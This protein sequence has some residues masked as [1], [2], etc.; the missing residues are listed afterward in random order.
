[1]PDSMTRILSAVLTAIRV[2]TVVRPAAA[3]LLGA[4]LAG[5]AGDDS[6][7]RP[8]HIAAR[9]EGETVK[10][11]VSE[12]PA[13]REITALVLVDAAGRETAALNRELITREESGGGNAGPGVGVGASGGSS[14][15]IHPYISLG[16]LF[17]GDDTTRRSQRMTAEI[18]LPDPAAYA[19]G[20]RD[21]HLDL[22]YR[23]QL[24]EPQQASIP[25]PAP[26][27]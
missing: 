13:G 4:L 15:G 17:R 21:W 6:A 10:V 8:M 22:R 9:V 5:C 3:L 19:A 25:A 7:R 2:P 26:G 11:E 16:Y 1:M 24:G 14:S 18:P 20:Y 27:G 23:D 12:I